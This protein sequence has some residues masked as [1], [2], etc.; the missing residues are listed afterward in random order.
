MVEIQ[1][2]IDGKLHGGRRIPVRGFG[3]EIIG[4]RRLR[5]GPLSMGRGSPRPQP[6]ERPDH[7]EL[8]GREGDQRRGGLRRRISR[9]RAMS[10]IASGSGGLTHRT[11]ILRLSAWAS[12]ARI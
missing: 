6:R 2:A 4:A 1:G 10:A 9:K 12:T 8:G 7:A 3:R 5:R 11:C